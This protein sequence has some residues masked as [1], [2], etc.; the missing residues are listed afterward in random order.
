MRCALKFCRSL[1]TAMTLICLAGM[2]G[3]AAAQNFPPIA[4][5]TPLPEETFL[6]Q[7]L[8]LSSAES[9]D[10][11]EG[12]QPLSFFWAFGDGTTSTAANP[13]HA[14]TSA[15]AYRVFQDPADMLDHIDE[16]GGRR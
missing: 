6:G 10:P 7:P 2:P 1:A 8:L 3:L 15:G 16:V 9:V 12:P 11:D 14:Y 4:R 5:A 13:L